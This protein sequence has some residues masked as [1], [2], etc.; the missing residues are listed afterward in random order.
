MKTNNEIIEKHTSSSKH[1]FEA[2]YKRNEVFDMLNEARKDERK[3]IV[4]Q[5]KILI[6]ERN[7]NDRN[8]KYLIELIINEIEEVD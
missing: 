3:V 4:E 8:N 1:S 5:L 7:L 2:K 6:K